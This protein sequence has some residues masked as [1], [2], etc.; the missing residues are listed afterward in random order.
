MRLFEQDS[1]HWPFPWKIQSAV[2]RNGSRGPQAKNGN[3]AKTVVA[4][5]IKP[6]LDDSWD[7]SGRAICEQT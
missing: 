1:E 7:I 3:L 4:A 5:V 2:F 6:K